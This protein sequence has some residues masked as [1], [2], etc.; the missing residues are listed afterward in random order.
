[1]QKLEVKKAVKAVVPADVDDG[2]S[3]GQRQVLIAFAL[4]NDD[5]K[6]YATPV[7][8]IDG[9]QEQ[10]FDDL[11]FFYDDPHTIYT[12]WPKDVWSDIDAHRAK[13]GMNELQTRLAL[14]QKIE[15]DTP[16]AEGNRTVTYDANGK[17]WTVTFRNDKAATVNSGQ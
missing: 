1:L 17:K 14:G 9:N 2:I 5:S 6:E 10:Y 16:Q 11:L 7:G 3:H 8:A 15:T 13:A 12:H 4:P